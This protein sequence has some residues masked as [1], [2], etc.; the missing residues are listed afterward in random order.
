MAEQ[1]PTGASTTDGDDVV[2][3]PKAKFRQAVVT[4][5]QQQL[6]LAAASNLHRLMREKEEELA[7]SKEQIRQMQLVLQQSDS[8]ISNMIRLQAA[9]A[10]TSLPAATHSLEEDGAFPESATERFV[11]YSSEGFLQAD[12][13]ADGEIAV[14]PQPGNVQVRMDIEKPTT[15]LFDSDTSI[16]TSVS[17]SSQLVTSSSASVSPALTD[18]CLTYITCLPPSV[19]ASP[20]PVSSVTS[21][22]IPESK[23]LLDKVLQQNARLKKTL[24]DLL[25]Q[26]GLSVSTYLVCY[27]TIK[28]CV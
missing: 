18:S 21:A 14:K 9:V 15:K 7:D 23:D 20:L 16:P 6:Q 4:I 17:S 2:K 26:K 27:P 5:R 13:E 8:R 1:L 12:V 10:A 28:N 19:I 25:G 3:I 22:H 24:R 11:R